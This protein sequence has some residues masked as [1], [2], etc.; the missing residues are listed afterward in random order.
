MTQSDMSVINTR[1]WFTTCRSTTSRSASRAHL[2]NRPAPQLNFSANPSASLFPTIMKVSAQLFALSK[3]EPPQL[4]F[5]ANPSASLFPTI[6]KVSA[7]LFALSK[8]ERFVPKSG[9]YPKGFVVGGAHCGVKKNGTLDLALLHNTSSSEA[10]AA[11][12]FTQNK[13]KAAPV[14][15]SMHTLKE[16]PYINSIVVN[17]GNANAVTGSQ[18]M[19]DARQM[20]ETTDRVF[21]NRSG[22]SS[23]VML[24]GVIGNKLPIDKIVGGIPKLAGSGLGASHAHWLAC[25]SAICTTD[26]F[27]KLVSKQFVIGEH[28]YTMAGLAKGAGMICPNMATLLGFFATDAPVTALALKQILKYATDRSFNSISVDGDT[29]TNDTIVAIANGAAGGPQIDSVAETLDAFLALRK[30]VTQ[31]AQQLAQLVVRDG[32]G[33][34]KFIRINVQ[35]AAL[36]KDAKRVALA[37]ANSLL[38]KTAMFG[39]DANWGRILCAI[40]YADVG[41]DAVNT[42]G[43]SVSFVPTDGSERLQLL[44]DGEP[45]SVDE[46]RA[47]EILK[48]ED[49]EIEICLG[50]GGGQLALFWTCDLSHEYVSINADYRS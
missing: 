36:Y 6:M 38:F 9:V 26:T 1:T 7:Q 33:A 11:A 23:L 41:A 5:S 4:N 45:E 44:V 13:F 24:T 31:F 2:P 12:V 16:H 10:V 48:N 20:V 21:G 32:E 18:G 49:L 46:A 47:A 30:E 27:P 50:T 19:Q 25:A 34:T 29:S 14:Q 8:A 15:V 35:D 39:N 3:A 42:A 17:S 37:V 40:G 28:T 22:S 43:T